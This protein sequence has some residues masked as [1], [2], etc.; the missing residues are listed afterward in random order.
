VTEL[1]EL[2]LA[3]L[4]DIELAR[5]VEQ[6]VEDYFGSSARTTPQDDELEDCGIDLDDM[7]DL[8]NGA[9]YIWNR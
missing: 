6:V 2:L 5:K 7:Q 9:P 4:G 3:V 8:D 1:L